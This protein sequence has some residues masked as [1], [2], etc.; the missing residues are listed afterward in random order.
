LTK[1]KIATEKAL[2][3][4]DTRAENDVK[5]AVEFG[6]ASPEPTPDTLF[7]NVYAEEA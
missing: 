1:N 6:E 4:I 7:E 3:E 5:K 2:N